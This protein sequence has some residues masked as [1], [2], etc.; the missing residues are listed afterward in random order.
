V[1]ADEAGLSA[2]TVRRRLSGVSGLFA[3]LLARA[4]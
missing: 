2:R 3:Y 1:V 4:T